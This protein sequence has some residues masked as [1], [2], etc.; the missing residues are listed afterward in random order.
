M[1]AERLSHEHYGPSLRNCMIEGS[2][3][4]NFFIDKPMMV[5]RY[6][7]ITNQLGTMGIKFDEGNTCYRFLEL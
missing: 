6:Q 1:F 5:L 2:G 4:I 7:R 3:I